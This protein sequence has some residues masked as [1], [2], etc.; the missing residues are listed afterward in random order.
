M[1][2]INPREG[3]ENSGPGHIQVQGVVGRMATKD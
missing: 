3:L 2:Y 1:L